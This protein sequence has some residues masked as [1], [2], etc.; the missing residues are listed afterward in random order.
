MTRKLGNIATFKAGVIDGP[1]LWAGTS[2]TARFWPALLGLLVLGL[3]AGKWRRGLQELLMYSLSDVAIPCRRPGSWIS[4][5]P[6]KW[7]RLCWA[8]FPR[9]V[10]SLADRG[11][12]VKRFP[13]KSILSG[14]VRSRRPMRSIQSISNN[15]RNLPNYR[16]GWFVNSGI[17]VH[18]RVVAR[19]AAFREQSQEFYVIHTWILS[20]EISAKCE[21]NIGNSNQSSVKM[22]KMICGTGMNHANFMWPL[23]GLETNFGGMRIAPLKTWWYGIFKGNGRFLSVVGDFIT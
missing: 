17:A 5:Q 11:L 4:T 2:T 3:A 1:V 21:N 8:E 12:F 18:I 6:A 19:L 10:K 16:P 23:Q 13:Y 7:G 14:S 22:Q 15:Y 9:V 20:W